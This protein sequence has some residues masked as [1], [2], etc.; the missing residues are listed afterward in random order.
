LYGSDAL[1]GTINIITN[2]PGI[3]EPI[4]CCMGS[5]ASTAPMRTALAGRRRLVRVALVRD[6]A[7]GRARVVRRLQGRQA[8]C[9][10]T[11]PFF[12]TGAL[13]R[14]DTIDDNFGFAFNAFPDPFNA[15]YVRTSNEVP[16]SGAN[17]HFINLS[18]R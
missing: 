11:N 10:D 2:E 7:P 5:T 14:A 1:A 18:G 16:N 3:L 4:A 17:G 8:D 15:P 12:A 6:P 13:N 9:E